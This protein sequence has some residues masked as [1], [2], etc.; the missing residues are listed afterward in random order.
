MQCHERGVSEKVWA[1]M[2]TTLSPQVENI[3]IA[4]Q[5]MGDELNN[6]SLT[7]SLDDNSFVSKKD[8]AK[9]EAELW[10][11]IEAQLAKC[12]LFDDEVSLA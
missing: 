2:R 4:L 12:D 3:E 8:Q 9:V 11:A 6:K 7:S 1:H 10:R 5:L